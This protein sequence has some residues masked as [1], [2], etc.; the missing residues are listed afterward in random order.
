MPHYSCQESRP[1]NRG[2]VNYHQAA[3]IPSI[4]TLEGQLVEISD[5]RGSDRQKGPAM[6]FARHALDVT[7]ANIDD[8]VSRA[9]N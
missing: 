4:E 2:S 6:D 7:E 5:P 8:T 9:G 3:S 1:D